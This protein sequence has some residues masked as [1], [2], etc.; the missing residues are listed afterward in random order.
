MLLLKRYIESGLLEYA[1]IDLANVGGFTEGMKV[2]SLCE[3]HYIDLMPHNPCGPVMTA[4]NI[5]FAVSMHTQSPIHTHSFRSA[6][7]ST[8]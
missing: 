4:A 3:S 7:D 5:H 2:A 1:R 6:I 8:S